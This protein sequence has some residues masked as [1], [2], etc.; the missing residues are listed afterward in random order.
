MNNSLTPKDYNFSLLTKLV[1][2]IS[3]IMSLSCYSPEVEYIFYQ[4]FL[5]IFSNVLRYFY[6]SF[7]YIKVTARAMLR[8]R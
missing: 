7:E 3:Y 8:Q 6:T 5:I 4:S 2:S 1:V